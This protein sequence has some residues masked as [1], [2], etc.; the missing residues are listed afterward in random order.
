MAAVQ[1]PVADGVG[2]GRV[3]EILVPVSWGELARDDRR[4]Q[5]ISVQARGR[6]VRACYTRTADGK[7]KGKAL[8]GKSTYYPFS[9]ILRCG[10]CG[11]VMTISGGSSARYY[12]C[13][14]AK[15]RGTCANRH[16]L[17]EDVARAAIL[18]ALRN[19][20]TNPEAMAFLCKKVAEGLGGLNR[21]LNR[22]LDERR[23]ALAKTNDSLANLVQ[24]VAD[25]NR[26]PTIAD[27]LQR[28]ER[29]AQDE[30]R[31]IDAIVEASRT[32]IRLP[33]PHDLVEREFE[34]ESIIAEDPNRGREMLARFFEG[35]AL[36]VHPQADGSYIAKSRLFPLALLSM[37]TK[38]RS[39]SLEAGLPANRRSRGLSPSCSS[40]SCAGRI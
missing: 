39:P 23:A 3:A 24:F 5:P 12:K 8:P 38:P 34:L 11:A 29:Q 22:D 33:L 19:R 4:A 9:G 26:S 10:V 2:E 15:K 40:P 20:F 18:G 7:P 37:N 35:G 28:Y 30:Q 1:E 14:A 32:P 27:T 17:R 21:E 16:S 6:E 13:S 31:Q 36:P 25:G